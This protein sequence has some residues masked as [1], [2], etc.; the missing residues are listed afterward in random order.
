MVAERVGGAAGIL[1][2]SV[3][4]TAYALSKGKLWLPGKPTG[5]DLTIAS[6]KV[7]GRRGHD[8]QMFISAAHKG[9]FTKAASSTTATYPSLWNHSAKRE[10][11][12]ACIPDSQML[13][14]RGM[15]QR[16]YELWKTA[17]RSHLT[18]DFRFTSQPLSVAFTERE[19]D[20]WYCLAE[21]NL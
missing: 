10:K 13:V 7:I 15:E 4:Q 12:M 1:D 11:R 14:K 18:L 5:P 16:A 6:L 9:P 19:V 3:A 17:S 2:A 8:H 21:C 20:R